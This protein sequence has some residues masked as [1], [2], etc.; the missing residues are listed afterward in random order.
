MDLIIEQNIKTNRINFLEKIRS[1]YILK[2]IF[3]H[4]K[5][6]IKLNII[7]YNKETQN[8]L[9]LIIKD[10]KEY[11]EIYS[12]IEI[13]IVPIGNKGGR[14]INFNKSEQFY[15]H[16]Y[17]NN[18]NKEIKRYIINKS[19]KVKNIKIIIDYQVKSFKDLFKNCKC[20][21]SINFKKFYRNNTF[22]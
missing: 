6:N 3:N 18:S 8:K 13:E 14:F 21:E 12:K 19:A 9:N 16:I 17:F 2:K 1:K 11:Q 7:K 5:T 20:I 15:F 4:L 22:I 10:Y